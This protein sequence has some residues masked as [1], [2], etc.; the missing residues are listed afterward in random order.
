MKDARL[1]K[2]RKVFAQFGFGERTEAL[3]LSQTYP[4]ENYFASNGK[5]E[6]RVRKGRESG[7]PNQTPLVP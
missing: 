4:L 2:Y 5:P 7:K 3:I 6:V 1:L